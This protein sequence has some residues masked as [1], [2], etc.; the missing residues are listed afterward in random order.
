MIKMSKAIFVPAVGEQFNSAW[1]RG[2][3]YKGYDLKFF[4]DKSL[5]KYPYALQCGYYGLF[6]VGKNN[7][8]YRSLIGYPKNCL[9]ITDS[10]GFQIASF[11]KKGEICDIQPIDSLRWQEAN[12]NICMNLDVPPT[13]SEVPTYEEFMKALNQSVENFTLFEK[14]RKNFDM[15]LYNVLHGETLKL[16]EIWYEK[17]KHF[18]FDGWALG[19]K[20]PYDPMIQAMGLMF[21]WEK[22]ELTKES[23]Y[24]LHIFGTSGKH[25]V[26]TII[27]F[28][29]KLQNKLVTYDSSSYNVGS[30]YRT[31]YLPFDIG[32]H[33]FFGDKFKLTNPHLKELPCQ[34]PVCSIVTDIEDLNK[35]DIQAGTLLS[36]HNMYQYI[37][38]SNLLNK[39][40][41]DKELFLT[42]LK[43]VNEADKTLK[44]IEF[45]DY[46]MEYGIYNAVEKFKNDLL[47]QELNKTKQSTIW[48]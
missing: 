38:Y 40:V 30:I 33:F 32:P 14:E 6:G 13:L 1:R 5:F 34:C 7:S 48:M 28:A 44:S 10:A 12:G 42:Y 46:A 27:Y 31:Y 36:L 2:E 23:C 8:D 37:Y 47:P 20:P 16:M 9:L 18:K 24:G 45:I 3:T 21:L 4:T 19:V 29:N 25:V 43:Q 41:N 17:V 26:P 35:I 11:K 39:I 22:G 15:K